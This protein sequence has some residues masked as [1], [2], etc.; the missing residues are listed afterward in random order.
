MKK[1]RVFACILSLLWILTLAAP[2][3]F[4][5]P[6]TTAGETEATT[7]P[8]TDENGNPVT[9][10][11]TEG[12]TMPATDDPVTRGDLLEYGFPQDIEIAAKAAIL[13]D[14]DSNT[15][16]FETN[17]DEQ[18]Y[19]ASLTKI[20]T[21]MLA[22]ENGNMDDVLTVSGTALQNL[23]EFG[24]TA[25]LKEGEQLTLR[26][27]LYCIMVSSANEGCNV[28]A[29]YVSGDVAT[30]V[31]LMNQKAAEL[32][33]TGT[34]Y[35]NTHGLHNDNHYTTV[36]DISIVARWAWQ[37]EQFREFAST[38]E[39]I[40]PATNLS[41]ERT[42]ETT[43]Y[44]T[45]D[46]KED[47]YYYDKAHGI[48]TGFTTPAGGCLV[49]TASDGTLNLMSVVTGCGTEPD[50]DGSLKDMRFVET[51]RL[52]EYGFEHF[53]QRQVLTD[54]TMLGQPTV[55]YAAGA[56][57]VV[58]RAKDNVS[59]LLPN[60]FDPSEITMR[61]DYTDSQLTAPLEKGQRVGTV[62]AL[63]RGKRVA[64]CDLVTLT[65]V[66]RAA[67]QPVTTEPSGQPAAQTG[68][69]IWDYWY[70]VL[71]LLVVVI[72]VIFLLL[73]RAA[74]ARQA[75]KRAEERRRREERR[76]RSREQ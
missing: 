21:C 58:V 76:S 17:I 64:S 54:T 31:D 62:V 51:K 1:I 25:G 4:A 52:F 65:A 13:V 8:V 12:W 40:V 23:S 47:K 16:L 53:S 26:E 11:P 70:I 50:M 15:V 6:E 7:E 48:K 28:I 63:Y 43:N 24:S 45:S 5:E 36:R 71:P 68:T 55:L 42:L 56:G 33:M 30:F 74:N 61:L 32:G 44:L 66:E 39:H 75:R 14:L 67:E 59:A 69:H 2:G 46:I 35:A 18:R 19:P 60:D 22:I 34:H 41:G 73:V 27:I 20:M 72:L 49:S 3:V 9:E 38:T 37:N 57:S 29:E 10:A